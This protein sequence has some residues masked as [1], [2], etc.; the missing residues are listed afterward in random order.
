MGHTHTRAL[1]SKL[2]CEVGKLCRIRHTIPK[3]HHKELYHTLFESHLGFGISVWGGISNNRL[4]PIFR[5][6]KKCVRA[7]FG[8]YR[9]YLEKFQTSAR[10]RPIDKQRLGRNTQNLS[11]NQ[12]AYSLSTISTNT[13]V[14]WKCSRLTN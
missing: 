7:M 2:K 1:N 12:I 9:T 10:T 6:Q 13:R 3:R 11:L 5:T 8:D 14:Y 4:E